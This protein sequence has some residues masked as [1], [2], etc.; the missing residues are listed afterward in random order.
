LELVD[1]SGGYQ[2]LSLGEAVSDSELSVE[3]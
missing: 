1:P 3:G 2:T